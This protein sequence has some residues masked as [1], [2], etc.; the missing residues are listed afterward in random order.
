M[1]LESLAPE[2]VSIILR[3]IDSPRGLHDLIAAS[4]ACLRVFLQTPYLILSAVVRNVLPSGTTKHYIAAWRAPPPS[5]PPVRE[6]KDEILLFLNEYF[7][8]TTPFE[9]PANQK[10]LVSFCQLYHRVDYLVKMF[11]HQMRQLG[12]DDTILA[13]SSSESTRLHRAFLR[14]GIYCSVFAPNEF[15]PLEN[16]YPFS[17][18]EQFDL[19]LRRLRPWEVE[20]MA[21]VQVYFALL[22]GDYISQLEEQLIEAVQCAPGIVWPSSPDSKPGE[23][24]DENGE[25]QILSKGDDMREFKNLDMTNLM[26]FSKDG[27][28]SSPDS[29]THM[30]SLGLEFMYLL[31]RSEDR[32]SELIR[33]NPPD[34]REFL[35]EA[36]SHSPAWTPE[37]QN[38][39]IS[40]EKTDSLDDPS[41][42][43]LGYVL[44]GNNHSMGTV[45]LPIDPTGSHHSILRRLG[46]VFWDSWRIQSPEVSDRLRAV[47]KMTYDEIH[48]LF[49]R[50]WRNGAEARLQ[51][52]KLP[53]D[54]FEKI[55]M[56]FG[57][58]ERPEDSE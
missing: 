27:I 16:T 36:L 47:E 19:F 38:Q 58:I 10:E 3:N 48:E 8:A 42:E 6:T 45:Y 55:E 9:Y 2:L 54:Q 20:E 24:T 31:C 28:Y 12:F 35:P 21:C 23:E 29:I 1:P 13:P 51:G 15:E 14:Y 4:P 52:V 37:D 17:G 56:E 5:L 40:I 25:K 30:T 50:P 34:Y 43:N 7:S 11:L 39:D 22:T 46:Y 57:Y 32:R 53:R 44:F 18:V 26:L 33:S 41:R 49:N